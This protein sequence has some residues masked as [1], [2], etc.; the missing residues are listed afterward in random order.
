[1][2]FWRIHSKYHTT[3]LLTMMMFKWGIFCSE[4]SDKCLSEPCQNG[5][6]CVDT[7][8]DYVCICPRETV[9]YMGK[10]CERLYDGCLF[11]DCPDCTSVPGTREFT[12]PC[13]RGLTGPN[14]TLN[15][16]DC[17]SAP[18]RPPRD[19]CVDGVDVH[20]CVCPAG[21]SGDDCETEVQDCSVDPCVNNGT[22]EATPRGYW[23]EC[24]PGF[25]GQRCEE[26]VDE[27]LSHPCR[28]GAICLDG[29]DQ[30][31]CFCVPGFQGYNCEIDINECA[32]RPCENNA[33]CINEKDRYVCDC[34]LGFTV[35]FGDSFL[36]T[37]GTLST[38]AFSGD[39]SPLSIFA[40]P[41][42][43]LARMTS[44]ALFPSGAATRRHL[45]SRGRSPSIRALHPLHS[46]V[47]PQ[48]RDLPNSLSRLVLCEVG[49][50]SRNLLRRWI[51]C[52]PLGLRNRGNHHLPSNIQH[53][54][55]DDRLVRHHLQ[56]VLPLVSRTPYLHRHP[57]QHI[58]R[59]QGGSVM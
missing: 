54:S 35:P 8:D 34:L 44:P 30:Y 22:C 3:L 16:D 43:S 50:A 57:R 38:A 7:M 11:A 15:I 13:P 32:S 42:G 19:V 48:F 28:N 49:R 52:P 45:H 10:D 59:P 31:H 33:T 55:T 12:C 14:C 26:D 51:H 46:T 18:C 29:V 41:P 37:V 36:P 47:P 17:E 23:C 40:C 21:Y 39:C 25:R 6:T 1:M 4:S 58:C 5:A 2:E 27:C 56:S 9:A 53:C 24:Q 20:F